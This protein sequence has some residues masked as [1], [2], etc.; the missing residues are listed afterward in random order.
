MNFITQY[1][2]REKK[3]QKFACNFLKKGNLILMYVYLMMIYYLMLLKIFKNNSKICK[4]K[5]PRFYIKKKKYIF[6]NFS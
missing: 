4:K 6:G 3:I 5:N 1:F 2:W